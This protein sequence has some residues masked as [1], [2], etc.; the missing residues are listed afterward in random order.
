M[1]PQRALLLLLLARVAS[2][3]PQTLI[4]PGLLVGTPVTGRDKAQGDTTT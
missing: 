1:Q 3:L 2:T 4:E